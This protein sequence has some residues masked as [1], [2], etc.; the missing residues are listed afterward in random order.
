MTLPLPPLPTSSSGLS[1]VR[2]LLAG[3]SILVTLQAMHKGLGDI[4]RLPM[5]GGSPIVLAGPEAGHFVA[6]T[7]RH[8][9]AWR[10][11]RDPVTGLLR[12]GLLVEDA[13]SHDDL[14]RAVMPSLHRRRVEDYAPAM[15]RRLDQITAAWDLSRPLDMLVEMRR[16]A[17]LILVDTLFDDDFT[18]Y[19]QRLFPA[20]LRMLAYISPGAWL[21]WR[22]I[23]RPG[24]GW[25][26]A[27]VDAYLYRLIAQR[28]ARGLGE[29]LLSSLIAAGM[30]DHLIRDQLLTLF[31]AGHDT[32]TALLAWVLY[33][34]GRYPDVQAQ[35]QAERDAAIGAALPGPQNIGQLVYLDQVIDETLRL[36][37][38]IHVSNRVALETL[39]FQG[40]RIPAG[41]RVMFSIYLTHRHEKYWPAADRFDPQRFA[42]NVKH[43]P[44]TFLPFGGGPRNCI[45]SFFAQ[46]EAKILLARLLERFNFTLLNPAV[47]M[48]MGA[49]LE[50]RPGVLMKVTRR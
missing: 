41:R 14:R 40:Y 45:G 35:A 48:H 21:L 20:I 3:E 9:L 2:S 17:L 1:A 13:Q 4:F 49:T 19:L 33:H 36:Y 50:P 34:F 8:S 37:P 32:S 23:P 18:P 31:I 22:D 6:V 44:Y 47:H 30:D 5:P 11:E 27:E 42:P 10:N 28:R 16:V 43:L 12:H 46:V 39:E 25:A 38:P 24:Y 29:D 26:L 15:L 7:A